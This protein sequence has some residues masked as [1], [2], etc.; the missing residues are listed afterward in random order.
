MILHVRLGKGERRFHELV[1]AWSHEM[2]LVVRFV[3]LGTQIVNDDED[4]GL[5]V[6][7]RR[8]GGKEE[9]TERKVRETWKDVCEGAFLATSVCAPVAQPVCLFVPLRAVV[10]LSSPLS[11]LPLYPLAAVAA[12]GSALEAEPTMRSHCSARFEKRSVRWLLSGTALRLPRR[13]SRLHT[14]FARRRC[15][16]RS[17][18]MLTLQGPCR[19]QRYG[20]RWTV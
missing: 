5:R 20:S 10:C 11:V 17:T 8:V 14:A 16:A 13:T 18:R 4:D 19:I 15:R 7:V 1:D 2:A 3:E 9:D 12:A 6:R